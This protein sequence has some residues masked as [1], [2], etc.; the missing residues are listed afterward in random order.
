MKV[1]AVFLTGLVAF[2]AALAAPDEDV[3][4][5]ARGYPVCGLQKGPTPQECLVGGYSHFDELVAAHKVAKGTQATPLRS[6]P[7]A[8]LGVE[9]F[10]DEN[11]N[12]GLLVLKGDRILAER[13][14]YDRKP[15][16]RFTSM[17]MAKTVVGMLIGIA[18]AEGKIASIDDVAAKYVPALK[19]EPYGETKIRDLLTMSSGVKFRETYGGDDDVAI[20]AERTV[21]HQGPGGAAAVK[22]FTER[23]Y[24][25][26]QHFSYASAE[27]EVLGLVLRAAVGMPLAD[28]L[29]QKIWQPMGAEADATWVVDAGGYELGYMGIN[30]TLRD[31][32]R[33]GL[34]LANYGELNGRQIIPAAWV[35]AATR[36]EAPHLKVGVATRHNG[37]GYQTWLIDDD[38]RFAALGLRG[39]AIFVDPKSKLVIVHT[40]VDRVTDSQARGRQFR[41]FYTVLKS[42]GL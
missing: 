8:S 37:Y 30:A 23:E 33:F 16:D 32:G 24:P 41:F 28:Y 14:N 42:K 36:P 5:K 29:S 27:S 2:A 10:M 21:Y 19:G 17:S 6:A 22:G 31:W 7:D 11:R 1:L 34:L 20:L 38:G 40:A 9:R 18:V 25:A 35:R 4:G 12:T 39:Q 15:T 26:G 13:Y 3:L